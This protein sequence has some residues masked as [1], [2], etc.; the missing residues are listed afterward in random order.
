MEKEKLRYDEIEQVIARVHRAAIDVLGPVVDPQTV[1][2]A[3]FSMGTV[4]GLIAVHGKAGLHEF[5]ELA[6][7]DARVA[8]FRERVRMV[9]D[10]EVEAAYP[11][12]WIGKVEVRT[13][14]GRNLTARVDVPKGD[15]GNPLTSAE[16]AAKAVRLG[17]FRGAA[18]EAEMRAAIDRILRFETEAQVQRLLA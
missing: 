8:R 1:H 18:T 4:L 9:A 3:K 6:L 7:R 11:Q 5:E 13:I 10:E 16:L 15:P 2:Q 12:R 14:D 17:R